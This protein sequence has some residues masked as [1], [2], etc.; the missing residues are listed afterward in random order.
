MA[1]SAATHNG[2]H[3]N[4]HQVL[5]AAVLRIL[6]PLIRMLLRHGIPFGVFADIA[7][8]VYVEVADTEFPIAGRKQTKSRISVL[9]GLSRKEVLRV[10]RLPS[11]D[12]AASAARYHRAARTISGWLRDSAFA[13]ADGRPAALPI[14]GAPAS[15]SELVKRYSGDIPVRAVLDEMERVGAVERLDDG[16]VRLVQRAYVPRNGEAEKINILG[17]DV[18]D[19]IRTIEHNIEAPPER[20]F[21]QRKVSYDHMPAELLPALQRLASQRA[22]ALLEEL[23]NWMATRDREGQAL[24]RGEQHKR[25]G[26]EIHYFEDDPPK[27]SQDENL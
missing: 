27:E 19:L 15:F 13:A 23:N 14:D 17:S 2:M 18:T 20:A 10:K 12:D 1:L 11:L 6:R 21:F 22:Q 26:V 9:T 4:L 16:R 8:R 25:A 5:N 24:R 3:T 7:R